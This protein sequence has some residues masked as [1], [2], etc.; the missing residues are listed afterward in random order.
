MGA[1]VYCQHNK[2]NERSGL[3][4]TIH[5]QVTKCVMELWSENKG[6]G[7]VKFWEQANPK[8]MIPM[9]LHQETKS[10]KIIRRAEV[11]NRAPRFNFQ[12]RPRY[13]HSS[14]S[15]LRQYPRQLPVWRHWLFFFF[16][17]AII[18]THTLK[19][20]SLLE[21]SSSEKAPALSWRTCGLD[22]QGKKNKM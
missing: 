7:G 14:V 17:K 10:T 20:L 18:S 13:G 15:L 12:T 22:E 5:P 1:S 11:L 19:I 21:E 16:K 2:P 6:E 9:E 4:T 3:F 8:V